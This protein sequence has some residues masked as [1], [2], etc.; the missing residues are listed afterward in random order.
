[1][2]YSS[3]WHG[4]KSYH[5]GLDIQEGKYQEVLEKKDKAIVLG[6]EFHNV[7]T[8]GK[9]ANRQSE[10]L[11]SDEE[12]KQKKFEVTLV[13]RGGHATLH[14]PGQLVIY[15]V[16][17][18]KYIGWGVKD[19]IL[20][21]EETCQRVLQSLGVKVEK[22]DEPGLYTESGKMVFLGLRIRKGISTHGIA[23]NISNDTS[24]FSS[25]LSCGVQG[26]KL[27]VLSSY[28][29]I[30]SERFFDLWCKEFYSLMPAR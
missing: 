27:D 2:N 5:E 20:K 6:F 21:L 4:L 25:I 29:E 10:V 22:K 26:E 9:R 13:D 16:L 12:L 24:H 7:I 11:W 15:P 14:S 18:L 23:V 30:Q 8:I 1:M 17:N 19:Y 28:Y 3:Q